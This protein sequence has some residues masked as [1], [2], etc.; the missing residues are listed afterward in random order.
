MSP[1]EGIGTYLFLHNGVSCE[2]EPGQDSE[3]TSLLKHE[4]QMYA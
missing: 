1:F 3:R 2:T 4:Q